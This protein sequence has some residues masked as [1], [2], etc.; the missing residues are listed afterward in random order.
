MR[1]TLL[2]SACL[3]DKSEKT[4]IQLFLN[5]PLI[6]DVTRAVSVSSFIFIKVICVCGWTDSEAVPRSD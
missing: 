2:V 5:F 4:N 1:N 6:S 3:F